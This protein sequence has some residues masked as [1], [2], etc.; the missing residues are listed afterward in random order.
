MRV[1]RKNPWVSLVALLLLAVIVA[2]L[3]GCDR[4]VQAEE[5]TQISEPVLNGRFDVTA[6]K[7]H[8]DLLVYVITDQEKD[9]Q[10]LYVEGYHAGGLL[11]MMQEEPEEPKEVPAVDWTNEAKYLAKT[12][13]GE[14]R[15]CSTTEQ[16]A[17]V[18]CILNRVDSEDP[19]YPDDI[20]GVVT[21]RDQFAGYKSS[22]PVLPEFYDLAL[23]IIDRW[24]REKTGEVEVGRV[25]PA[26]Y[27]WF[28]GDGDHNHFRDAY[29]GNFNVWDWT[30]PSPYEEGSQ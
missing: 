5:E 10:Y 4:E 18:W 11:P 21:Q 2:C 19:Y 15:G 6:D 12:I 26:E 30:L 17:V 14:A 1:H 27:L 8:E 28:H 29:R 22:Y 25:L 3:I 23:D 20:I 13:W 24:Q 7:E 9:K 16:A